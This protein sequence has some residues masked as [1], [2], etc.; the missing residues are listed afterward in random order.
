MARGTCA[1]AHGSMGTY[2]MAKLILRFVITIYQ[3]YLPTRGTQH[4][5]SL[6]SVSHEPLS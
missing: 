2:I 5:S 6:D 3:P 1:H 4:T